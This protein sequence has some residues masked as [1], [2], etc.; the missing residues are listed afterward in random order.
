MP[1]GNASDRMAA[2]ALAYQI[3]LM[4]VA[5]GQRQQAVALLT[6]LERELTNEVQ[7]L[8]EA[9][10]PRSVKDQKV[11]AMLTAARGL[12]K[13]S[14]DLLADSNAQTLE[15]VAQA[16]GKNVD[17]MINRAVGV[18][19]LDKAIR[20]ELL[21]AVLN[22]P[23]VLGHVSKDWW[24]AQSTDLQRRFIGQM[25]LG[26]LRGESIEELTRRVRGTKANGFK[27]GIME[28]SKRDA[29]ALV[30]TSVMTVSN[31]ARLKGFE[32][33]A[34]LIKAV[35]WVATLDSRTTVICRGLNQKT[36]TI[37]GY[38]PIGHDKK[39]PGPIAHWQ[40]R[41]TQIAVTKSWK[42]LSGKKLKAVD[43]QT[44]QQA[45]E[46]KMT[47][48]GADQDKINGALVRAKASMD[49][50]VAG[51]L[52]MDDWI[53][54]KGQSFANQALGKGRA[55][56]FMAG[57][58]NLEDLTDQDNRP[59]TLAQL[60]ALA[61]GTVLIPPE[62]AG[63]IVPRIVQAAVVKPEASTNA[64][65]VYNDAAAVARDAA[66]KAKTERQ[67]AALPAPHRD[68]LKSPETA[69]ARTLDQAIAMMSLPHPVLVW[70]SSR[71]GEYSRR[72]VVPGDVLESDRPITTTMI[73]TEAADYVADG[74][75]KTLEIT[76]PAGTAAAW[77]GAPGL[78]DGS[79]AVLL[80]KGVRLIVTDVVNVDGKIVIK[81]IVVPPEK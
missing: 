76:I 23:D 55:D 11:S 74:E 69:P 75:R 9:S 22:Q 48:Q 5:A 68:A 28:K 41:S 20:P 32:A 72:V 17:N 14:Y 33:R 31:A 64:I 8:P 10:G 34:E 18:K 1:D 71:L 13:A 27:D 73:R 24:A 52:T 25:Q 63:K 57:R 47:A 58:I 79:L 44:L 67:V 53:K 2:D 37:P 62:T 61:D 59:L 70:Q 30:R 60:H 40:C 45:V 65:T 16:E 29:T 43:D 77:L 81:A 6:E 56:L 50:Q 66:L 3:A 21:N 12:I 80:K 26:I 49:G 15:S 7:L 51:D 39:F 46:A 4:R 38:E 36:W 42:E 35:Q 19:I 78:I 54:G